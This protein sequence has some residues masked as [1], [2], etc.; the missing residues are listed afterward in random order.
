MGVEKVLGF[1]GLADGQPVGKE[2]EWPT[3]TLARLLASKG[4][5][6][7]THIIDEEDREKEAKNTMASMRQAMLMA[8]LDENDDDLDLND[9]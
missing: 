8:A 2:D 9:D 5:I 7:L 6:D 1:E 3:I 4:G